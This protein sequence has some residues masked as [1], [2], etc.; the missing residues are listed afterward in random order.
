MTPGQVKTARFIGIWFTAFVLLVASGI[1]WEFHALTLNDHATI[2]EVF[3]VA[4]AN[5]PGPIA[6]GGI[7]LAVLAGALL[8]HLEWQSGR[9][10]DWLRGGGK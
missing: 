5:A 2:S 7:A 4:W 9:V 1:A 3:W 10:Y 8:G 6:I